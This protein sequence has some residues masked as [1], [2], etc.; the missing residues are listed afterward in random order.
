MESLQKKKPPSASPQQ[1]HQKGKQMPPSRKEPYRPNTTLMSHKEEKTLMYT[2]IRYLE[3]EKL[4]PAVMFIF[5]RANCDRLASE[6]IN[7]DL[8]TQEEKGYIK[9]FFNISVKG[10]KPPD[11]EIPQIMRMRDILQRGVGVHHSGIL[12]IIK[13]V[14]EM[15]FQTGKLKVNFKRTLFGSCVPTRVF[16]RC[17]SLQKL[18]RW[19]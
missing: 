9:G 15:L 6:L 10:L 8:T 14:V 12:P 2:L 17:F 16:I 13:E 18:S 5:S 7:I 3:K 1:Q 19:V 11:R 4:L